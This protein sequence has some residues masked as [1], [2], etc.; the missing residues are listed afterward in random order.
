MYRLLLTFLLLATLT[1]CVDGRT[2]D[3]YLCPSDRC[4]VGK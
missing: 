3:L 2:G 1:A 4:K